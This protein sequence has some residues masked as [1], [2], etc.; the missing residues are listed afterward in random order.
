M[1]MRFTWKGNWRKGEIL[2]EADTLEELNGILDKLFSLSETQATSQLLVQEEAP[3]LQPGLGC[4]DAIKALLQTDWGK[5]P[6]SMSEIKKALEI[7]ALYVSKGTLSGTLSFLTRHG[8][9]RRFKKAGTWV[10]TAK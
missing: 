1:R 3:M 2:I 7:N 9:L 5:Q 4:S 8:D 6:R 10:Y